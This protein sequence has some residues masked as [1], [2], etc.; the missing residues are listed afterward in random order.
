MKSWEEIAD[1]LS[2]PIG[3]KVYTI[4]ELGYAEMLTIQKVKAGEPTELDGQ[5]ADASWRLVMGSAWDEMVADN[6]PGEALARAGLATLAFFEAGREAA[7]AI[8][9][10]GIDPKAML[11]AIERL[12]E[13]QKHSSTDA[14]STTRSTASTSPTS[15][16]PAGSKRA[17][18]KKR[19]ASR[20]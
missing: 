7:E 4:P 19:A 6:V 11:A 13:R 17:A 15:S 12:T 14:E 3:G 8:W 20:S 18:P 2:F 9:E 16:R 1:T 10:K 5:P